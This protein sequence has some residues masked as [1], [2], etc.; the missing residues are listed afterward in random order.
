MKISRHRRTSCRR[1]NH[2]HP[3]QNRRHLCSLGL[4][5]RHHHLPSRLRHRNLLR[6]P[7]QNQ[8]RHR[9]LRHFLWGYSS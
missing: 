7:R 8:S 9:R 2:Y 3:H 5:H 6:H 1:R 4:S